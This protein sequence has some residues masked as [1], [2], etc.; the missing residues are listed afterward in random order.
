MATAVAAADGEW[1]SNG[2]A[3]ETKSPD[4]SLVGEWDGDGAF[5]DRLL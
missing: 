5:K 3:A 1:I 2:G 4:D